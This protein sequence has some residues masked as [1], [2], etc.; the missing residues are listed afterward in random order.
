MK[1]KRITAA[2]I[3]ILVT[4]L[5]AH[6]QRMP[7]EAAAGHNSI[8]YQ[9]TVSGS[10][11]NNR[12]GIF[13]TTSLL[14]PFNRE[15]PGELMSQVYLTYEL[16]RGMKAGAGSFYATLPGFRPSVC[17]QLYKAAENFFFM[18]APRIDLCHRPSYDVMV[19]AEYTPAIG[20]DLHLYLRFQTMLNFTGRTHNRSYQYFRLGVALHAW[21]AGI[22]LNFDAYGRKVN[23]LANYGVFLRKVMFQ[24]LRK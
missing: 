24:E 10:V 6:G 7:V 9:H 16:M 3:P 21:Q 11:G 23:Y 5:L 14:V 2:L 18:A 20:T 4:S 8:F 22:A 1:T 19:L 15:R 12:A 13:N 17:V